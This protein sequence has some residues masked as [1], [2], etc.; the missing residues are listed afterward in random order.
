M[1]IISSVKRILFRLQIYIYFFNC[2]DSTPTVYNKKDVYLQSEDLPH[3]ATA[4][5]HFQWGKTVGR[6]TK[7]IVVKIISNLRKIISNIF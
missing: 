3:P 5:R 7:P 6:K 4:M 2:K 1:L